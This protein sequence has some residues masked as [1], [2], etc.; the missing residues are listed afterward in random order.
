M[1]TARETSS[2]NDVLYR[3]AMS[4]QHPNADQLDEYVR[5]YPAHADA[6]TSL[7]IELALERANAAS[8]GADAET[9][10]PNSETDAMLSRAMSHF[11]NRLYEMQT[12]QKG[13]RPVPEVQSTA[14]V[15]RDLFA[16][17]TPAQM[18]TLREKLDVS[19]LFLKR[20][21]DREISPNTIPVGFIRRL[22]TELTELENEVTHFLAGR[23]QIAANA[24][25]KSDV[26][27]TVGRQITFEE[28]VRSSGM[29]HEQQTRLLAL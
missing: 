25:F 9:Y 6:L 26:T 17:R 18:K 1:T 23:T 7:A 5:R 4:Y 21:R 2:E 14:A 13:A 11:Q 19:P 8:E 20:V 12:S 29:T 27:P 16:Q 3:F 22:A 28:A 24:R 10:R 15:S